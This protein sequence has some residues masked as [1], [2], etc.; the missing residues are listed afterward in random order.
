[1]EDAL[2]LAEV[3][4]TEPT[5]GRALEAFTRP[6]APRVNWVQQ[7]SRA[8][9]DTFNLEPGA[10]N[11]AMRTQGEQRFKERYAPLAVEP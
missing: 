3:L 2:V 10:R 5:L 9:A 6:R 11:A 8:V 7:Q 1:M 4:R